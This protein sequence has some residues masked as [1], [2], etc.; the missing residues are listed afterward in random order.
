MCVPW[1]V[2]SVEIDDQDVSSTLR[3]A[4]YCAATRP[5]PPESLS[6]ESIFQKPVSITATPMSLP[7]KP[8]WWRP[9]AFTSTGTA[10]PAPKVVAYA[11]STSSMSTP[12]LPQAPFMTPRKRI[13]VSRP[14][15][16]VML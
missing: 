3:I 2:V 7:R 9:A 11:I 16:A 13:A 8:A 4:S 5:V 15:K 12:S 6:S 10:S 1:P 14:R